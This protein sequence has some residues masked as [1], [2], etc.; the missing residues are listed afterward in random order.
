MSYFLKQRELL[1][2]I[3]LLA[4]IVDMGFSLDVRTF[5]SS[6]LA[7]QVLVAV[8]AKAMGVMLVADVR[9]LGDQ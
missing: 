2:S 9:A 7:A 8:D 4:H 1:V 5:G 3:T 6:L